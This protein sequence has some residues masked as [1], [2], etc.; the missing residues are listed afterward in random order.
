MRLE[1]IFLWWASAGQ[2]PCGI[3]DVLKLHWCIFFGTLVAVLAGTS[4]N[5][6]ASKCVVAADL[7]FDKNTAFASQAELAKVENAIRHVQSNNQVLALIVW[8][9]ADR[10]EGPAEKAETLSI[11]RAATVVSTVLRQHPELSRVVDFGGGGSTQPVSNSSEKN[12]RVEIEIACNV[13][14]PYFINGQPIL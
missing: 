2:G 9:H 10:T 1:S 13:L 4:L 7:R 8:G 12:R 5:A 3:C 11:A 6:Q 14:P